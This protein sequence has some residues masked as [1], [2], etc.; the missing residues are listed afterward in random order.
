M[1]THI[2]NYLNENRLMLQSKHR[3]AKWIQIK[4]HTHTHIYCLQETHWRSE[5]THRL[6]LREWKKLFYM[7]GNEKTAGVTTVIS[8]KI[9]FITRTVIR[10]K[11]TT[12][13]SI[14]QSK[15]T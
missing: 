11:D 5:Y 9:D 13:W 14:H 7:N 4:T 2:N 6:K 10:N 8:D 3:V 12:L 1:A 15:K